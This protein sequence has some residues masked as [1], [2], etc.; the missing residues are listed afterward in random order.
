MTKI[1]IA[2]VITLSLATA[3]IFAQEHAV[4]AVLENE[5]KPL[6]DGP[7]DVW[8]YSG[9]G[10]YIY[11]FEKDVCGSAEKEVFVN[12]SVRPNIWH[13]FTGGVNKIRLGEILFPSFDFK[14]TAK[15]N[16]MTQ[17][18]RSYSADSYAT[19]PFEPF[20]KYV[21][22]QIISES[23][24]KSKVRQV[25]VDST[26]GEFKNLEAE[27]DS[28][29]VTWAKPEIHATTLQKLLLEPDA[30]WFDF[31]PNEAQERNGFWFPGDAPRVSAHAVTF[32]PKV[33]LE[34][35]KQ[36]LAVPVATNDNGAITSEHPSQSTANPTMTSPTNAEPQSRVGFPI[37]SVAILALVVVIM[38]IVISMM[39]R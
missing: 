32:T 37:L 19:P 6:V 33:A 3:K 11:K 12:F 38:G 22:E 36:K 13:I 26:E 10:G 24:V 34:S 8:A 21:L 29:K 16:G 4:Y 7:G 20:G 9:S 5:L 39:R 31:D 15:E 28:A 17:V 23:G 1:I 18:L 27:A 25:G 2:I 30:L 35:L 14:H